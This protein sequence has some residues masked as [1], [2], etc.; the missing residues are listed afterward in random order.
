MKKEGTSYRSAKIN[1]WPL[2]ISAT[3]VKFRSVFKGGPEFP[4][5]FKIGVLSLENIFILNVNI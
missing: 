1:K 5:D 2:I 4:I 3:N